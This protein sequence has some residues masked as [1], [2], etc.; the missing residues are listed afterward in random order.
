MLSLGVL[1]SRESP[2]AFIQE[3]HRVLKPAGHL[4]VST[5]HHKSL[6]LVNWLRRDLHEDPAGAARKPLGYTERELFQLLKTGF[7]VLSVCTY[8]KLL[9]ELVRIWQERALRAGGGSRRGAGRAAIAY[10]V[11]GQFDYLGR[12]HVL[13]AVCRRRQWRPR[14]L[15]V[16][17]DGRSIH[18]A[19][20]HRMGS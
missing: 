6:S 1:T 9:V 8:C 17:S 14:T 10:A 11:A 5:R 13:A 15:P 19:V 2:P 3:C 7:D 20:L 18:E 4:I 16:L 12:G